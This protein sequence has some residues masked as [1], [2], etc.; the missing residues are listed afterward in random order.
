MRSLR[1]KYLCGLRPRPEEYFGFVEGLLAGLV[2]GRF[3]N[4]SSRPPMEDER[5]CV[6]DDICFYVF[7]VPWVKTHG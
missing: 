6:F 3:S 1:L 7:L 4:I 5:I 2:F